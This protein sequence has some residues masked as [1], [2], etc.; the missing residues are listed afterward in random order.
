MN[1]FTWP[2]TFIIDG[3]LEETVEVNEIIRHTHLKKKA[4][5]EEKFNKE[6]K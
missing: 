4:E 1:N 5:K 6:Q 2:D 3:Y